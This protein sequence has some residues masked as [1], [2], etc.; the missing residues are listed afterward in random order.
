MNVSDTLI[1]VGAVATVVLVLQVMKVFFPTLGGQTLRQMAIVAGAVLVPLATFIGGVTDPEV[2]AGAVLEGIVAGLAAP[3][4]Y[5][6]GRHGF[7]HEV[8]E[9]QRD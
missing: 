6:T 8:V 3:K 4:A 1:P 2:L 5:E 9:R 7:S